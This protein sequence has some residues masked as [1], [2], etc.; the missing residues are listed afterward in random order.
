MREIDLNV[1]AGEGMPDE[2]T[3]FS[4]VTSASIGGG[5][6]A[7]SP[8]TSRQSAQLAA[9]MGLRIGAHPGFPDREGFG[10][11]APGDGWYLSDAMI[12]DSLCKQVDMLLESGPIA[13]LKP[14]GAL[15]N[16]STHAGEAADWVG[17][18]VERIRQPLLGLPGS[19]HEALGTYGFI[20]EGFADRRTTP[21][22][23]LVPRTEPGAILED[24]HELRATVL[25]VAGRVQSLCIHGDHPKAVEV[26]R[27][28]R[29]LLEEAGWKV[30]ARA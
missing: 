8:E 30:T 12:R 27:L 21:D 9:N 13:Y 23:R 11:R 19:Y 1:D 29:S 20:S 26:A 10:R 6:H 22:G 5:A 15:Y 24:E 3:L 4:L 25:G 18:L 28:V 14:H 16:L 7:G 2:E 17:M